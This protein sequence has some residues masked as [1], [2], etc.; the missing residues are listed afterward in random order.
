MRLALTG[1]SW[2]YDN[3]FVLKLYEIGVV[4]VRVQTPLF[5]SEGA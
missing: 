2:C 4:L 3:G 5:T 1:C